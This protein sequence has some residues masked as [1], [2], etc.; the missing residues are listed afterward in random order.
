M[1]ASWS[2]LCDKHRDEADISTDTHVIYEHDFSPYI[3]HAAL[4]ES[5]CLQIY[6]LLLR[7][8]LA[9]FMMIKRCER[10]QEHECNSIRNSNGW[11][12]L[13]ISC[14]VELA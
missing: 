6:S 3:E 4:V 14:V 13:Q 7:A 1:M 8:S 12:A 5:F 10:V 9:K 11:K 2:Q